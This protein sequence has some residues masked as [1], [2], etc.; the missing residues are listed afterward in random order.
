MIK[1]PKILQ[2]PNFSKL[3]YAGLTSELGSFMT[4]TA[5]MLLVFKLSE[6]NKSQL[7]L[8]RA[9]FLISLTIGSLLGGPIGEKFNRRNVLLFSN[10]CR[11]PIVIMLFYFHNFY[12]IIICDALIAFFT[13]IYNP[14][15]Q[16]MIND[17]VPQKDIIGA[18]S[19][20]G[21]TVAILHMIGPFLGASLF[22]SFDG[23]YEIITFDLL[24]YFLGIGLLF[25][26]KYNPPKVI[27]EVKTTIL[28][29]LKEGLKYAHARKDLFAL[30]LNS[31]VG[32]FCIGVLIPLLLPFTSEVLK[33]GEAEYGIILSIFG[34]G[35]IFG[36][37]F[38]HKI[39]SKYKPGK[40][41]VIS[42]AVEPFIMLS[43]LLIPNFTANSIIF[44]IWGIAVFVRIPSQLN[45]VSRTVETGY[46]SRVH[47]ILDL[48]F[49][50]PNISG[51]LFVA[52]L[53]NRFGTMEM[54]F[55]TA[56]LFIAMIIPRLLSKNMQSLYRDEGEIVTRDETI[57]DTIQP[58]V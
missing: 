34:L 30:L 6:G 17:I 15:R 45:Y 54:L 28:H 25:K 52:I 58:H 7:G 23:I 5:L 27:K 13:G 10:F 20:F 8:M 19:L 56:A 31:A 41:I 46:L 1:L 53:G 16:A 44:F 35:G 38:C 57:Q 21:A 50:I 32:G 24:T 12:N 40:L 9:A 43:W 36:G 37:F 2:L 39:S 26:M 3:Y 49:V 14:S 18:N 29:D 4:E 51:G 33:L 11:I 22:A 42:S 55:G 47:S 48:S